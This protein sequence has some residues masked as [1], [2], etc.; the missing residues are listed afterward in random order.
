MVHYA[1]NCPYAISIT[2]VGSQSL[3]MGL[4]M[5]Q[6]MNNVTV[7]DIITQSGSYWIHA[8]PYVPSRIN[9]LLKT[10]RP[11][12]QA[13]NSGSTQTGYTMTA[14]TPPP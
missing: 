13:K 1:G 10:S 14:T 2:C 4:I 12:T 11:L 5:A 6:K 7:N 9:T 3:H 8:K